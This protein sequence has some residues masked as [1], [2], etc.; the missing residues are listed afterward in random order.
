MILQIGPVSYIQSKNEF[1]FG[2][3]TD[4]SE[5]DLDKLIALIKKSDHDVPGKKC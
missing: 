4:R 1:G 3:T 2:C 5:Q